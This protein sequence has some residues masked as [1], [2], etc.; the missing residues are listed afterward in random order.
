MAIGKIDLQIGADLKQLNKSFKN[1]EDRFKKSMK[2]MK[3]IAMAAQVGKFLMSGA[4]DSIEEWKAKAKVKMNFKD[5]GFD[6]S[7][8]EQIFNITDSIEKIGYSADVANEKLLEFIARGKADS[9]KELGIVLDKNT[10]QTLANATAQ[11]RMQWVLENGKEKVEELGQA[12]PPPIR[13]M[14]EMR[15]TADDVKKSTGC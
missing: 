6:K 1:A 10:A 15:K 5:L 13:Q 7:F 3:K 14:A 11:E 8:A 9:L 12:M 2:E 4:D